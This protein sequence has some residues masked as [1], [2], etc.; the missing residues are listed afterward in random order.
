MLSVAIDEILESVE[1]TTKAI[2]NNKRQSCLIS[3]GKINQ[4]K[5]VVSVLDHACDHK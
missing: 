2:Y 5:K 1:Y 3:L 4:I